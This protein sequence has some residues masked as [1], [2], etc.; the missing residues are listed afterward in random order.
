MGSARQGGNTVEL[1]KPF[2]AELKENHAQVEYIP[3]HDKKIA[4]CLG[5]YRCQNVPGE[6]GCVQLDD[7]Q[8]LVRH[9]LQADVLVFA[10]PIY[11]WQ[12]N[13]QDVRTQ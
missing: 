12:A 9:I 7:M 2:I 3:L 1:C 11:T 6:Y 13:G 10:T 4:P 8:D 5:C